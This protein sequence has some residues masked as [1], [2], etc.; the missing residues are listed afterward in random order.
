MNIVKVGET[1]SW[2]V[3]TGT[4]SSQEYSGKVK[5]VQ[6]SVVRVWKIKYRLRGYDDS[7]GR[8]E[9]VINLTKT[10]IEV[11]KSK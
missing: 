8:T 6:G 1:I 4:D 7:M 5:A 3:P 10:N 2:E 11:L 9:M